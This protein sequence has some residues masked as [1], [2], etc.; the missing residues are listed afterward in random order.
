MALAAVVVFTTIVQRAVPHHNAQ[1]VS[2]V[3][4]HKVVWLKIMVVV[5]QV[6]QEVHQIGLIIKVHLLTVVLAV[7]VV[8][9]VI[10]MSFLLV[11]LHADLVAVVGNKQLFN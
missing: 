8:E 5:Q 10:I 7:Q 6:R 11:Y 4:A 1:R 3:P 2:R 9:P